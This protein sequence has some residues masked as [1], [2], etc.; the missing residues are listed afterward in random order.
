M[1]SEYS[2]WYEDAKKNLQNIITKPE[3]LN[4]FLQYEICKVVGDCF[5]KSDDIMDENTY[6]AEM[7]KALMVSLDAST[8]YDV[9]LC[10]EFCSGSILYKNFEEK[11]SFMQGWSLKNTGNFWLK[12]VDQLEE[13][14]IDERLDMVKKLI[15]FYNWMVSYC[16]VYAYQYMLSN[17]C[18]M[19]FKEDR[20]QLMQYWEYR[21]LESYIENLKE[22]DV[23]SKVDF[24]NRRD[25]VNIIDKN[26]PDRECLLL[27][28]IGRGISAPE[29]MK[30]TKLIRCGRGDKLSEHMLERLYS[31]DYS[32]T[33]IEEMKQ[34]RYLKSKSSVIMKLLF[35][36]KL[37]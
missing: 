26:Y 28:F 16:R 34:I 30:M 1:N 24:L 4:T 10:N 35:V 8:D 27:D 17:P 13:K 2:I 7:I 14:T 11:Y 23:E 25:A 15:Q 6:F 29:A 32:E 22:Y 36:S 3:D 18:C 19:R 5:E 9:K 20:V 31:A 37:I 21:E 33:L 12:F